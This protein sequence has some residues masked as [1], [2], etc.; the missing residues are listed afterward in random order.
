MSKIEVVGAVIN[1]RG[2]LLF[3]KDGTQKQ[4]DAGDFRIKTIIDTVSPALARKQP[5]IIDLDDYSIL[6]KIEK[7]SGGLIKFFKRKLEQ[8][9]SLF[10]RRQSAILGITHGETLVAV[11]NGVEIEGTELLESQIIEAAYG[12]SFPGFQKFMDRIAAV[13]SKRK[14][15][16][17]ELLLFMEKG[18][19]P[20]ADDG[21]IV[22][23]KILCRHEKQKGFPF[24]D[25]H[26]RNVPQRVGSF[27][28]MDEKLVD[29]NRRQAC[30]TG[31]HVA[32]RDY[33]AGFMYAG[34]AITLVKVAPE[35]VIAVPQYEAAKMRACGYLIVAELTEEAVRLMASR[36]ALTGDSEAARILTQVLRGNH[37][38][39]TETVTIGA[40]YGGDIKIAYE[41][42]YGEEAAAPATPD[43]KGV[44]ETKI[45]T[46]R[47]SDG[48]V[49][50]DAI[51]KVNKIKMAALS[52]DMSAA[53]SEPAEKPAEAPKP[54]A[55][56]KTQKVAKTRPAPAAAPSS[57]SERDQKALKM[58]DEGKSM[59]FIADE[60]KMCRK[61]MRKLFD[62]N[63]SK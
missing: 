32:R 14:H 44:A 18:D 43:T 30:S 37:A 57:L 28:T 62:A 5:V 26:S 9:H 1:Q 24:V 49:P 16:V 54:K 29:D 2:A 33:V 35:D 7:K 59:R 31:L 41:P 8:V 6:D 36:Q 51:K 39:K 63:P 10:G 25:P 42:G 13:A 17:D 46:Q 11:V 56:P 22:G 61:T 58:R 38:Q 45:I 23:Y 47:T 53:I 15:S 40:A 60:L 4:I 27:V 55:A 19:L 52:G 12:E 20:I 34:N 3:L 48:V 50:E 21:C